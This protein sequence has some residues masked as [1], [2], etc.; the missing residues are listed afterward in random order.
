MPM[1]TAKAPARRI[2]YF[3]PDHVLEHA[4]HTGNTHSWNT[5]MESWN[6]HIESPRRA[7]LV[8]LD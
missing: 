7:C 1:T 3:H 2:V 5:R 8:H 6:T 4:P